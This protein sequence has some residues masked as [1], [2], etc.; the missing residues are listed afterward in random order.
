MKQKR[1]PALFLAFC[2]LLSLCAAPVSAA[3]SASGPKVTSNLG[4]NN[5]PGYANRW[6]EPVTSYLYDNGAGY[7]RVEYA[8]GAV[9][10]EN[11]DREFQFQSGDSIQAELPVWGGFFAGEQ[12]NFLIFG[13]N[14]EAENDATEVVRVVKYDK[15]WKRLGAVGLY[16][17]NTIHPF[18]AGSLRCAEHDGVLYVRTCHEMYASSDGMNHQSNMT[19]SVLEDSMT[20]AD[21][22]TGVMNSAY[23]YVSHSFNQFILVDAN[24]CLVAADHG[25]AY[26]R[27]VSVMFYPNALTAAGNFMPTDIWRNGVD[28]VDA[29]EIPGQVGDNYTGVSVGG[30]AECGGSYV[31]AYDQEQSVKAGR[32]V[33]LAWVSRNGSVQR[34]QLTQGG[35]YSTPVLAPTGR[36]GG[37]VLWEKDR[38]L[39]WVSY[40][41][42]GSVSQISQS[43]DGA[44]SDCTPVTAENGKVIWYVTDGSAVTFY[45]LDGS[46]LK[47]HRQEE[48]IPAAGTAYQSRQK[49]WVLDKR[50]ANGVS[51][52]TGAEFDMYALHD[53]QGNSTNY[54]RLRDLAKVLNGTPAQFSVTWNA[55][56]QTVDLKSKTPYVHDG[57]GSAGFIG[58]QPYEAVTGGTSVDGRLVDVTA[59]RLTGP[60]G[61]GHTYYKLRDLGRLLGFNVTWK[62]SSIY[63]DTDQPYGSGG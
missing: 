37:Y 44:L 20:V 16:G 28:T 46:G 34:T 32:D 29:V 24:A 45:E 42:A 13:Q 49:A 25:D 55:K 14:N 30:F 3:A 15:S 51:S 57:S 63:I 53:A 12:Y 59:I 6:A 10:V 62:D 7:T 43:Q 61:G 47:V 58:D 18:D 54:V 40:D 23:G 11:Y 27:S 38:T 26:P 41:G 48:A 19:F 35:G 2:L 33:Y 50:Q 36:D 1:I 60:D 21:K 39:Y 5:Y 56:T 17:E 31:L 8:S 4:R 22:F 52:Y 9:Q